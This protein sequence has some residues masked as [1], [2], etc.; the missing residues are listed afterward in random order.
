MLVS[1]TYE[2]LYNNVQYRN[3]FKF[4]S[5]PRTLFMCP[6]TGGHLAI[7]GPQSDLP[8]Q[9]VSSS[10]ESTEC[11]GFQCH[12]GDSVQSGVRAGSLCGHIGHT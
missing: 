3:N 10:V 8:G 5:P 6:F 12:C 9:A 7:V 4:R 2:Y 1:A 11:A